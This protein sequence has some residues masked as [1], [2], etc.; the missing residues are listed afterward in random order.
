MPRPPR[1]TPRTRWTDP[2]LE[3][4]AIELLKEYPDGQWPNSNVPVAKIQ[5]KVL[6]KERQRNLGR[7]PDASE[8]VWRMAKEILSGKR[9]VALSERPSLPPAP[10]QPTK[11]DEAPAPPPAPTPAPPVLASVGGIEDVLVQWLSGIFTKA[12]KTALA[13]PE[14][15]MSLK[16]VLPQIQPQPEG[17][18]AAAVA[19]YPKHKPSYEPE[20][21]KRE[22]TRVLVIG[23]KQAHWPQFTQTFP[24]LHLKFWW[25]DQ[26]SQG[27]DT[28]AAKGGWADKIFC[29][30]AATSHSATAVLKK[31][32]KEFKLI[33]GGN[34]E[35]MNAIAEVT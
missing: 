2:E 15:A 35:L 32:G 9:K 4:L 13:D 20:G 34:S 17:I 14:L 25:A 7:N 33:G 26:P 27:L 16:V 18:T 23:V 1:G 11:K 10:P 24:E 8:R 30:L 12:V 29:S 3:K 21:N 28:L 19:N 31:L 22:K 6:P 5:K